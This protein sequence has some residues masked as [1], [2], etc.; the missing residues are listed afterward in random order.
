[1]QGIPWPG[2]TKHLKTRTLREMREISPFSCKELA[3]SLLLSALSED[4]R[5]QTGCIVTFTQ[6]SVG[7]GFEAAKPSP[8]ISS[9]QPFLGQVP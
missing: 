3:N 6:H 4:R 7:P 2:A 9:H 1:M 5:I 8:A